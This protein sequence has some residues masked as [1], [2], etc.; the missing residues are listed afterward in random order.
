MCGWVDTIAA[1]LIR[2]HHRS[3]SR[4]PRTDTLDDTVGDTATTDPTPD[5]LIEAE[6]ARTALAGLVAT[7]P[8]DQRRVF[9]ARVLE[10]RSTADVAEELG[11]SVGLVRWRLHAARERLRSTLEAELRTTEEGRR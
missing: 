9:V 4:R 3:R 5:A 10:D 1:N 7:L 11:I 2:N 8:E 6:A